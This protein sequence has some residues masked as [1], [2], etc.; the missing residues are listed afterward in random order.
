MIRYFST[1]VQK[2]VIIL[3][4]D[5]SESIALGKDS[6][7]IKQNLKNNFEKLKASFGDKY[8]ASIGHLW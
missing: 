6:V 2:P 8:E 7:R 1:S 4:V 5:N 3:A